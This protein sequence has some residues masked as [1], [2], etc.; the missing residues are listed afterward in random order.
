MMMSLPFSQHA[1]PLST[2]VHSELIGGMSDGIDGIDTCLFAS[3]S[4]PN[5]SPAQP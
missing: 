1:A 5:I 3:V 4:S 2:W